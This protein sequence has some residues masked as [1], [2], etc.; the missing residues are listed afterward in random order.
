MQTATNTTSSTSYTQRSTSMSSSSMVSVADEEEM[1]IMDRLLVDV[2][3]F[4]DSLNALSTLLDERH[5]SLKGSQLH[6]FD[7][8]NTELSGQSY[9]V[10][11]HDAVTEVS[12]LF[13]VLLGRY[14]FVKSAQLLTPAATLVQT[15]KGDW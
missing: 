13:K 11:V 1:D 8:V 5:N 12:R 3:R 2:S 14:E 6:S 15:V 9:C 10:R 4:S 7:F